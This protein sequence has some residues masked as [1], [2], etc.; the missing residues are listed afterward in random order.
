MMVACHWNKSS[1]MGPALQFEGG[2]FWRSINS[3][4]RTVGVTNCRTHLRL[5]RSAEQLRFAIRRKVISHNIHYNTSHDPS[6]IVALCTH[7]TDYGLRTISNSNKRKCCCSV[8]ILADGRTFQTSPTKPKSDRTVVHLDC[9]HAC[10]YSNS[11]GGGTHAGLCNNSLRFALNRHADGDMSSQ[12]TEHCL[13]TRSQHNY[14][15]LED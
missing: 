12:E 7:A 1:P 8:L 9:T 15:L 2:S 13:S 14:Y 5:S 4:S 3:C 11:A 10:Q 6:T